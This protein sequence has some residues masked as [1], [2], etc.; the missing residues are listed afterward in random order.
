MSFIINTISF[1]FLHEISVDPFL[2]KV[3]SYILT[4][5]LEIIT[6]VLFKKELKIWIISQGSKEAY[7]CKFYFIQGSNDFIWQLQVG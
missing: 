3:K 6:I 7:P 1:G 2:T 4:L 5:M